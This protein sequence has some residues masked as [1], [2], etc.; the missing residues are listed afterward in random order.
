M[1]RNINAC[2]DP[3]IH[4]WQALVVKNS[5]PTYFDEAENGALRMTLSRDK[6]SAN[7]TKAF[8]VRM[9]TRDIALE[10]CILDLIDNSVDGAW[11]LQGARPMSLSDNTKLNKYKIS[12]EAYPNHFKIADN[13]GGITLDDAAEYAFTFGR[14]GNDAHDKYSIGVYGIGMKRAVFKMGNN[15]RI[16]STFQNKRK[17]LEAFAVPIDVENWLSADELSSWDF[18]IESAQPSTSAGVEVSVTELNNETKTLFSDPAFIQK[19]RRTISR[20]YTL[21]LHR[22]LEVEVNGQRIVGWSIE[23]RSSK[24]FAPMRLNYKDETISEEKKSK[25]KTVSVEL[26][27]GMAAPPPESLDPD[28]TD[29]KESRSGWYVGCNGRIVLAADKSSVCGWGT[30]DWPKW[31]PQYEG[32]IGIILFSSEDANLLP[33]TTTKRSVDSASSVYRRA[34][35]HMREVSKE[36]ISYTNVRKQTLD[37]AKALEEKAKPVAI[38]SIRLRSSV[39]LPTLTPKAKRVMA[40]ISYSVLPKKLKALAEAFGSITMSNREVGLKSFDH[41]Y[42]DLVGDD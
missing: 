2:P 40:N 22:G 6:A 7:P 3:S 31:H 15:I 27:A 28:E 8:F 4:K 24:D 14:R 38:Y 25:K 39:A 18:D 41:A 35:P 37:Q 10:D 9:I 13:C 5:G 20:D 32:F 36:W 42:D 17:N 11:Q 12:I 19:L 29:S 30:D 1:D 26:L 34:M 16:T 21:H 33:L 23:M